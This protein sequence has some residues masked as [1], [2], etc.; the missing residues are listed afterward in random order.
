MSLHRVWWFEWEMP[1]IDSNKW[2]FGEIMELGRSRS[3]TGGISPMWAQ[4]LRVYSLSPGLVYALWF[5]HVVVHVISQLL[6]LT[7]L[8]A[9]CCRVSPLQWTHG[10]G[11]TRCLHS[12]LPLPLSVYVYV[13]ICIVIVFYHSNNNK[14]SN[15]DTGLPHSQ[16]MTTDWRMY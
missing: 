7:T 8:P 11:T 9:T 6:A 3:L 1:C 4:T 13:Y 5:L 2:T 10:P 12:Y 16:T 14:Q 15:W